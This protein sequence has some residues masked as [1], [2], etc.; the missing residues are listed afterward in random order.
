MLIFAVNWHI[1][2]IPPTPGEEMELCERDEDDDY[3]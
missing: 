2:I 1:L 3:F